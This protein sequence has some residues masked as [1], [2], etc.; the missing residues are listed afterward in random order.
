[1]GENFSAMVDMME[2]QL[3]QDTYIFGCK[4]DDPNKI[5]VSNPTA[6][7]GRDLN[8]HELEMLNTIQSVE[9]YSWSRGDT[10][11][12]DTGFEL[13]NKAIEGG[14][15]TSFILFAASPNVGKS[16]FM[17]KLMKN[18]AERN[19]NAF[20]EYMSL[21][22]SRNTILPRWIASDQQITIGQAKNPGKYKDD[23][24]ILE[25]R[26]EGI[27]NLYKLLNR[28]S[29]RDSM[30]GTSIEC[31]EERIKYLKMTLPEETKIVIGV[32]SL[33]DL[34]VEKK[35][36]DKEAHEFISKEVKRLTTDYDVCI[37]A[38]A[39]LRKL[40]GAR[41]PSN[42]DLK[43]NNRLEYE[44]ELIC[45]LYN[46]VG[47]KEEAADIYWLGEDEE[48]KMPVLEMKFSKNKLSDFKGTMF[49]EMIPAHS[50]FIEASEEACQRYS[51]LVYQK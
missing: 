51:A 31:L 1:M 27:K 41:R 29:L 42:D 15:Q 22:D 25:R 11:G 7:L 50:H 45:L 18:I 44:A 43:E 16:A 21:D 4:D 23:P 34:T 46:E 26:A 9:E 3:Q 40:N 17:L 32:D 35:M 37:M 49:Y 19:T 14:I 30:H 36:T 2:R 10:G 39:H 47:I 5:C 6:L 20:C 33:Y 13:F 8:Q 28:F 48:L 12:L 24:E 38:T